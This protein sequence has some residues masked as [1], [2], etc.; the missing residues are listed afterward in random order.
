M[1]KQ[2]AF[3]ISIVLL[4]V[5]TMCLF[6]GTNYK[7]SE[8]ELLIFYIIILF[9]FIRM[10]S[11][12][13]E[14]TFLIY[15]MG[16][17]LCS[18]PVMDILGLVNVRE[19]QLFSFY[20]FSNQEIIT[21]INIL[22]LT[23]ISILFAYSISQNTHNQECENRAVGTSLPIYF[24]VIF[25]IL[26]IATSIYRVMSGVLFSTTESYLSNFGEGT[27]S[28][29]PAWAKYLS[30]SPR[31]IK[32]LIIIAL[33]SK[34][35][36]KQC[37][38]I[39]TFYL[40][41]SATQLLSGQRGP[42]I[43]ETLFIIWY[44]CKYYKKIKIRYMLIPAS[45]LMFVSNSVSY[46]RNNQ[47][48][49]FSVTFLKEFFISQGVSFDVIANT[50]RYY[51]DLKSANTIG[52]P[53]FL[54]AV[55]K[56]LVYIFS[57]LTFQDSV[58]G[59]G[60]TQAALENSSYLGWKLTDIISPYQY[61]IG[62]GTGSSFVAE[63][64]LL[65]RY[66]GVIVLTFFMIWLVLYLR[67]KTNE[68]NSVYRSAVYFVVVQALIYAPRNNFWIFISEVIS[69]YAILIVFNIVFPKLFKVNTQLSNY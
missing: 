41:V 20:A 64:Y 17:F 4:L 50:V 28:V 53:Y 33:A 27:L 9:C 58:F 38:K 31:A 66:F 1:R 26:G 21:S 57:K 13:G 43:V 19:N 46:I 60:Q 47:T 16:L 22:S 7:I 36:Q 14:I 65:F 67:K 54:G 24:V 62:R 39:L 11:F 10:E 52:I 55:H 69:V 12:Y 56:Y 29:G 6:N 40:V 44:Y 5:W 61:S 48:V 51:N 37:I 8:I 63:N 68:K 35:P 34:P 32:A 15:T 30:I 18:Y 2:N 49:D 25:I 3:L 23:L 59:H 45:V 42:F